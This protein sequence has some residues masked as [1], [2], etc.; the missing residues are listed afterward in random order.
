MTKIGSRILQEI[1]EMIGESLENLQPEIETAYLKMDDQPFSV[2]MSAKFE[3]D[4]NGT[5]YKLKISFP[6][7]AKREV[8][9]ENVVDD[10]QITMDFKPDEEGA[11]GEGK[12]EGEE[13][14]DD[15][16]TETDKGSE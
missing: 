4:D 8:E 6:S 3:P 13:T 10:D 1:S 2:T 7:G 11:E 12:V 15:G 14:D 5:K 16:E 9:L